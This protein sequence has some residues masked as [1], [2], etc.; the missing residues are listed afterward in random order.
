MQR[1]VSEHEGEN[2]VVY[3]CEMMSH[4]IQGPDG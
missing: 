3:V 4:P 2:C 1:M